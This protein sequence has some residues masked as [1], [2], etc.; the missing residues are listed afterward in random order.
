MLG[1]S[2]TRTKILYVPGTIRGSGDEPVTEVDMASAGD[3]WKLEREKP[4]KQ[5]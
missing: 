2:R 4:S 1:S 3:F 5:V